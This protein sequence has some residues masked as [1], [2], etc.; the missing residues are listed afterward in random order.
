MNTSLGPDWLSFFDIVVANCKKPL[1]QRTESPFYVYDPRS[2]N[3]KGKKLVTR[4]EL[5]Q[6]SLDGQLSFTSEHK[7]WKKTKV[8]LEG[9]ATILSYYFLRMVNTDEA[10]TCYFGSNLYQEIFS[11]CE[12]SQKLATE[13]G[14]GEWDAIAVF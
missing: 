8:F 11:T 6:A 12:L 9:N 4:D 14:G 1:W 10:K 7:D 13:R 2:L 3:C 5:R